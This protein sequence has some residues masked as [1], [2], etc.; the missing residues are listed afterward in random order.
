M[1][2]KC[3]YLIPAA[4]TPKEGAALSGLSRT[5][6]VAGEPAIGLRPP[7][8]PPCPSVV[9]LASVKGLSRHILAST[10]LRYSTSP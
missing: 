6:R 2:L 3:N 8:G 10:R 9:A 4:L 5:R 1:S 7:S